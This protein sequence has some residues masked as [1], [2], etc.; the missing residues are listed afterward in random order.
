M[1]IFWE[2]ELQVFVVN[3]V[4]WVD[5]GG[6]ILGG[7]CLDLVDVIQEGMFFFYLKF[8]EVG[9]VN[10]MMFDFIMVNNCFLDVV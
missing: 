6:K 2:G 10:Q 5:I 1:L 4:Y 3:M 8:Y 9:E 7:W